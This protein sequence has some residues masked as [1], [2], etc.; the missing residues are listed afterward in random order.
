[1]NHQKK[2]ILNIKPVFTKSLKKNCK[3]YYT[4][5][6][7]ASL[8]SGY[9]YTY[10]TTPKPNLNYPSY[11]KEFRIFLNDDIRRFHKE[12]K[13]AIEEY[14]K[15][16]EQK[17]I[18]GKLDNNSK[19]EYENMISVWYN[20]CDKDLY[21]D[22]LKT[23]L[24]DY[25]YTYNITYGENIQIFNNQ[26]KLYED[27]PNGESLYINTKL[28]SEIDKA[29]ID[30]ASMN[31]YL[32]T[33]KILPSYIKE[34]FNYKKENNSKK[35]KEED[36][37]FAEFYLSKLQQ[38]ND[39]EIK[40]KIKPYS[41]K[42]STQVKDEGILRRASIIYG[43]FIITV[44]PS[45]KKHNEDNNSNSNFSDKVRDTPLGSENKYLLNSNDE[46]LISKFNKLISKFS[47][48]KIIELIDTL[49]EE[50]N[51]ENNLEDIIESN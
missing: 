17:I 10:I 21:P 43:G 13:G 46:D 6:N 51:S 45:Y 41:I 12:C 14:I 34:Y 24:E 49:T 38:D 32:E 11:D 5:I 28:N 9:I 16:C 1:M 29:S 33:T 47:K 36:K 48:E 42:L 19:K 18:N 23:L 30:E 7:T 44:L 20:A 22:P 26:V 8:I 35:L 27:M 2:S 3:T 4:S 50:H 40:V 31:T 39:R 15:N 25:D 37:G